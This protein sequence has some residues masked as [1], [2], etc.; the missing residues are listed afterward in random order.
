VRLHAILESGRQSGGLYLQG[1]PREVLSPTMLT[2]RILIPAAFFVLLCA[3]AVHALPDLRPE[4][5]DVIVGVRGVD[6]DDVEEGCAGGGFARRLIEFSL[7]TYNDGDEDL[8]LGN[9]GCPNCTLNPGAPCNNPLF[10]CG[11]SHGHAHFE[12]FA[13]TELINS[14]GQV[15]AQGGKY[16]FCLLDEDCDKPQYSCSY[17]GI[18]AGC[19]DVYEIGLPCQYIDITE[20]LAPD[21][22]YTLRISIDPDGYFHESNETNN[23]IEV[24]IRLGA[25]ERQCTEYQSTDVPKTI[26]DDISVSSTVEIPDLGPVTSIR[27]R[28]AGTHDDVGQ[29][30]ATLSSPAGT[31]ILVMDEECEEDANF[32]AYLGDEAVGPFFCPP[33]DPTTLRPPSE[34]MEPFIGEQAAGTWTLT[35]DDFTTGISGSLTRWSLEIC[36]T[37]GNGVLDEGEACDDGNVLGDDCCS[38]DCQSAQSDG[39]DCDDHDAC[40]TGGTCT[41]GACVP[42]ATVTCDP[43]LTCDRDAGC[44][45]PDMI[46]PCQHPPPKRASLMMTRNPLDPTRDSFV[47]KWRSQTPVEL[48]ELGAPHLSTDLSIC[49]YD[50]LGVVV[51]STIPAQSTCSGEACWDVKD[52]VALFADRSESLDG[53]HAFR[54]HEGRSGKIVVR[55]AG[56]GLGEP[57]LPLEGPTTV[58]LVR[59][60]G[61]PCWQAV[62]DSSAFNTTTRFKARND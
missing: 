62:F 44:V 5:Y 19:S 13:K 38:F 42:D 52:K 43:C 14:S 60:D 34:S 59:H 16:G 25:T 6:A 27:L 17:Q 20:A 48:D 50:A 58:R 46:Y 45:V 55:G 54:A 3:R 10:V 7:R 4:V 21:G 29:L 15:V 22:D 11:T 2:K 49:V 23:T 24:P 32:D 53:I 33:T 1:S 26:V 51:S 9:P 47:W 37:C 57:L 12:H 35:M 61:T 56:T 36:S 39:T 41:E 8:F 28:M 40:T 30:V 18:T 31:D